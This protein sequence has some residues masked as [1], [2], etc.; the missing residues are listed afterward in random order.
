VSHSLRMAEVAVAQPRLESIK[1]IVQMDPPVGAKKPIYAL[2][3]A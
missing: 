2:L 1:M 3:S